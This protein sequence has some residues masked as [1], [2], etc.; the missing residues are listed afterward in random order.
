VDSNRKCPKCGETLF[1]RDDDKPE[2][3]R[4]RLDVYEK[5]TAPLIGYYQ[6]KGNLVSVDVEHSDQVED[7]FEKVKKV[8]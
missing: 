6:S 5:Q 4:A 3:V 7:V 8:L 1:V 2:T